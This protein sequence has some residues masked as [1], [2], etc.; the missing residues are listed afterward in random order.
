MGSSNG[1]KL[2]DFE[3]SRMRDLT[4]HE[5]NNASVEIL[6]L[7]APATQNTMQAMLG[8]SAAAERGMITRVTGSALHC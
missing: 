1:K 8:S 6:L 3:T 4:A 5:T 2:T 7:H